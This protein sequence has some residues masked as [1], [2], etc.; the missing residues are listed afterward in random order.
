MW[1]FFGVLE[2]VVS[3]DPLVDV[4]TAI[5]TALQ[6]IRVP[7]LDSLMVGVSELGDAA[8]TVP[9]IFVVLGWFIWQ[10]ELRSALY[11]ISAVGLAEV[12][13]ELRR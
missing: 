12:F 13:V 2:D 6:R 3:H 9:V 1:L 7:A 11:W 10:R 8:V 4:D 5:H